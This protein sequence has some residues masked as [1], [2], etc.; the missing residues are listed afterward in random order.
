MAIRP[1]HMVELSGRSF[2]LYAGLLAEAHER[3]LKAI[4][5]ELIQ[6]PS[7]ANEQ[8]AIMRATVILK[9]GE[10]FTDYGDASPRN[11]A[12]RVASALLRMASTRAKGRALRDAVNIGTTMVEELSEQEVSAGASPRAHGQQ[13]PKERAD[14]ALHEATERGKQK[15]RDS[16]TQ[17]AETSTLADQV[18]QPEPAPGF[19]PWCEIGGRNLQRLAL[20][21]ACKADRAQAADLGL[22][23]GAFEP[24]E[25]DNLALYEYGKQLRGR[26]KAEKERQAQG[27]AA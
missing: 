13:S 23:V 26:I 24:D 4:E 2:V 8:T 1:E 5:V 20:V 7:Q 9:D 3:G 15:M 25:A 17:A 22:T 27:K 11:T 12:S 6:A 21:N 19:E 10:S 14:R 18:A 16:V